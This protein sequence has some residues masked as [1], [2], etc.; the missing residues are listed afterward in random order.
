[1]THVTREMM[2]CLRNHIGRKVRI[3]FV[4]LGKERS[5]ETSFYQVRD[6]ATVNSFCMI[7]WNMAVR[8]V[9]EI[10]TGNVLFENPIIKANSYWNSGFM[11][12]WLRIR[13]YGLAV[14]IFDVHKTTRQCIANKINARF[15]LLTSK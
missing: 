5:S 11:M 3:T 15:R 6:F 4:Q 2:D 8:K 14:T 9:E 10:E 7:G 13:S 1:M 12:W